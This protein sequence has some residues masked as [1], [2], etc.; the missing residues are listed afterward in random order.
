MSEI[1]KAC[2]GIG[3]VESLAPLW[4]MRDNHTFRRLSED[5]E[6]AA[7]QIK[8]E[9]DDGYTSGMLCTNRKPAPKGIHADYRGGWPKFRREIITWYAEVQRRAEEPDAPKTE[10][11]P[12]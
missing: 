11:K 9:W 6:E 4:Y 12:L 8:G 5:P 2:N 1:C 10:H 3:R 7:G